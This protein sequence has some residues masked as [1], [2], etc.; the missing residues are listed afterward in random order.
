MSNFIK[1]Q[2]STILEYFVLL[3][4]ILLATYLCFIGGYG[5]DEDTLPMFGVFTYL[6]NTG[7]LMTSR[8]TG[9]P[10]AEIGLGFLAYNFGSFYTNIVTFIF[11]FLGIYIFVKTL[12]ENTNDRIILFLILCLSNHFLFFDNL[13]PMDYSWALFFYSLGLFFYK[14]NI[15]ELAILF[16]AISIGARIN[17]GLFIFITILFF[18]NSNFNDLFS[19]FRLIFVIIFLGCLFYVP[20]WYQNSF[21]LE[22]LTAARPMDQGYFGLFA[23]FFY[24]II[25]SLNLLS[26]AL[27][28]ILF[29]LKFTKKKVSFSN[30]NFLIL[31]ILSNL[32]LFLWIPSEIGYIQIALIAFYYFLII[33]FRREIIYLLILCNFSY[34]IVNF[35]FIEIKYKDYVDQCSPKNAVS[36]RIKF[37]LEYGAY[38]NFIITRDNIR[39]WI[40]TESTH[41][42]K[43]LKGLPLK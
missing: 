15:I 10:V 27:I 40:N 35:N 39:C 29:F 20:V 1:N 24:K 43:V 31:I 14:K 28:L 7:N 3:T 36:A 38:K 25:L 19:K 30:K 16:F 17:F 4:L 22:W 34:W 42:K 26:L 6:L 2:F 12:N 9:Y 11:F 21:S 41:G 8:F 18:N 23:R 13:E 33:N 32:A 5:S 37:D